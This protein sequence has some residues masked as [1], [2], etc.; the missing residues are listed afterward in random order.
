MR[1][2]HTNHADMGFLKFILKIVLNGA[3]IYVADSF[4]AGF[5]FIGDFFDLVLAAL[6]LTFIY[7]VLGGIV[8]FIL[9]PL[10]FLTLGIGSII[11]SIVSVWITD[12]VLDSITISGF[13]PLLYT[14]ILIGILN[15]PFIQGIYLRH[16]IQHH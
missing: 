5:E 12:I 16:D 13:L 2:P 14:T 6:V 4:I 15:L 9:K 7:A 3:A 11:I 10:I 8:R 1:F